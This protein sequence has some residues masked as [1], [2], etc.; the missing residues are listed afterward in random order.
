MRKKGSQPRVFVEPE[1][2]MRSLNIQET[3]MEK[4]NSQPKLQYDVCGRCGVLFDDQGENGWWIER[5][6]WW[7]ECDDDQPARI[8]VRKLARVA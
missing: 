3:T 7:H 4:K 1:K 8:V 2:G 6:L 5:G